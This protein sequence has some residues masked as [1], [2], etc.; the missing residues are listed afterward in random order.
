MRKEPTHYYGRR[1]TIGL[2]LLMALF[3]V[4]AL[5]N[6]AHAKTAEGKDLLQFTSGSHVLGFSAGSVRLA[7][8]THMLKVD[9]VGGNTIAPVA[10]EGTS[11]EGKVQPL[12]RVTYPN[13][14]DGVD[15]AYEK[16]KAS[17]VKSTYT[18]SSGKKPG[19]IRLRYNRPLTV[20]KNGNLVITYDTGRMTESKPLAWQVIEGNKKPVMVA[21]NLYSEHELGF[22]VGDYDKSLPLVIDPD[23]VWNTFLGGVGTD[24]QKGMAVDGNGNV[25]VVGNSSVTWQGI[26]PINTTATLGATRNHGVYVAKVTADGSLLWYTLL[27]AATGSYGGQAIAV[28]GSGH[29]YVVGASAVTWGLAPINPITPDDN[30]DTF[31]AKLTTNGTLL[32]NTFLGGAGSDLGNAVAVDGSGNIYVG[33]FSYATWG[34]PIRGFTSTNYG[35]AAK[36]TT[37]GTLLW[38]TFLGG[39]VNGIALDGSAN[40]YLTGQSD[41]TWGAPINNYAGGNDA[42][43]AKLTSDGALLWNTFLGGAGF[44]RAYAIAVDGSGNAYIT[45]ESDAAWGSPVRAYAVGDIDAFVAKL[46]GDGALLWNTFLG[47]VD[48]PDFGRAIALDLIGNV[49]VSGESDATWG[50]PVRPASG[51]WDTDTFLAK[52]TG[53]GALLWNTFLGGVDG[54][55][56]NHGLAVHGGTDVYV[57]GTSNRDTWGNPL[58][59]YTESGGD[60]F[61]AKLTTGNVTLTVSKT[62]SGSVTSSPAGI[63]CGSTC[64]EFL[65]PGDTITLTAV[66]QTGS[67]LSSWGEACSGT[68][69]TCA[70]TVTQDMTATATFAVIPYTVTASVSGGHGTVDPATQTVNYGASATITMYPDEHYHIATLTDNGSSAT[71]AV[72]KISAATATKKTAASK[73]KAGTKSSIK[74]A[75]AISNPYTISNVT[76]DHAVVVTYAIDTYTLTVTASGT[77]PT[78]GAISGSGLTCVNGTCTGTYAYGTSVVVTAAPNGDGSFG[79]WTNCDS[80]SG[81]TCTVTMT[82]NKAVTATFGSPCTYAFTPPPKPLAYRAGSANIAVKA[83]GTNCGSPTIGSGDSWLTAAMGAFKNNRGTLKLTT[84]ANGTAAERSAPVTIHTDTFSV[85]QS[86]A[87]CVVPTF[88]PA[89]ATL[90]PAGATQFFTATAVTGCE[91][92]VSASDWITP[93]ATSG[94]GADKVYYTVPANGTGKQRSGLIT[95]SLAAAPT[96][97]RNFTVRQS[98]CTITSISSANDT[99]TASGGSDSFTVTAPASCRWNVTSSAD[100]LTATAS[101]SETDTVSYEAGQ[102]TTGK[103]RSARL[104]VSVVNAPNVKKVFTVKQT[105]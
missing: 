37:N 28:D 16:G 93:G 66:P 31:V 40:I 92:N 77:A 24:D 71:G 60:T 69:T 43:A 85:S 32:W 19:S 101:G 99:F 89:S 79:G 6:P 105:K 11:S 1:F 78:L 22:T 12:T 96:K 44:D 87:P 33:G 48:Y 65:N 26:S 91:W 98:T 54:T 51:E 59:G 20:D 27:G 3:F 9:F 100:W 35:Y 55:D 39:M 57:A 7:S 14:W 94:S 29:V 104:T 42:F 18:V 30:S 50:S 49:Y 103:A 86:G 88:S 58:R 73:A 82:S 75:G 80:P 34:A 25:F 63:N 68:G 15:I 74:S 47:G 36:L 21:Y 10:K 5:I 41:A 45:G 62:G 64:S 52:L 97:K 84:Q 95:V 83:T 53:D 38:N 17:I 102:N 13:V 23:L 76:E 61:L 56:P 70:V 90:A 67:S 8:G 46:T 81:N 72:G 4:Y 2:C